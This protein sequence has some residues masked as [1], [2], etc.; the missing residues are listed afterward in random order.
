MK[1]IKL[2]LPVLLALV[3]LCASAQI[4]P[5][6]LVDS[7]MANNG[8]I[9]ATQ[10]NEEIFRIQ[11]KQTWSLPQ[12]DFNLQQGQINASNWDYFFTISQSFEGIWQKKSLEKWVQ[13]QGKR[14]SIENQILIK[15]LTLELKEL[16]WLY[17]QSQSW[18]GIISNQKS[19]ISSWKE[20]L[21]Q[22]SKSGYTSDWELWVVNQQLQ[23][24][25]QEENRFTQQVLSLKKSIELY[26]QVQINDGIAKWNLLDEPIKKDVAIVFQESKGSIES[27]FQNQIDLIKSKKYPSPYVGAF[28]QQ[29]E[30]VPGYFGVVA[31]LK[32]PFNYS[33]LEREKNMAKLE[34][35]REME[36][37]TQ[38][39]KTRNAKL[40][41]NLNQLEVEKMNYVKTIQLAE[42]DQKGL[43]NWI[44]NNQIVGNKSFLEQSQLY[45]TY[46]ENER[47]IQET[48]TRLGLLILQNQFLTQ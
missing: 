30:S 48:K 40:E 45:T 6:A 42:T 10:L 24:I 15:E 2:I 3:G 38:D 28:Q 14:N 21:L 23:K 37:F 12:T 4:S 34:Y 44:K 29:L 46:W 18:S 17:V 36:V 26:S 32:V 19:M 1:L 22:Q 41:I 31:G 7:M 20:Q 25:I 13:S 27:S 8:R 9:K 16:I 39:L 43:L 35:Q 33:Y 5:Q 11:S 47:M